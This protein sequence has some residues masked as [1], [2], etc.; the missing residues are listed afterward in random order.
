[1][2]SVDITILLSISSHRKWKSTINPNRSKLKFFNSLSA[3][4]KI[5]SQSFSNSPNTFSRLSFNLVC[6][7]KEE[8]HKRFTESAELN[9]CMDSSLYAQL[10]A[11]AHKASH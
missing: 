1:M 11:H 6:K 3:D 7:Y 10:A 4:I 8:P 9:V 5:I 2:A